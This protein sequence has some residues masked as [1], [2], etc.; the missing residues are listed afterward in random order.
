MFGKLF[1]HK[2]KWQTRG[3]NKWGLVTYRY[4]LKCGETQ[5]RI[6]KP[7]EDELFVK[8]NPIPRLDNQF[9]KNN[10]LII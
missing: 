2:H 5:E 3:V 7:Y 9:D 6:N 4:C 1:K 10:N 8:C